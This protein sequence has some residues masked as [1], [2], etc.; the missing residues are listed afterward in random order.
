MK[1]IKD[2]KTPRKH[3]PEDNLRPP[4]KKGESGNL[5]G[6]PKGAS[7]KKELRKLVEESDWINKT[8]GETQAAAK[9]IAYKMV[10]MALD[11]D[12]LQAIKEILDRLYGKATQNVNMAGEMGVR[13]IRLPVK[14]QA[15]APIDLNSEIDD[16]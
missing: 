11:H 14:K 10:E 1:T 15:G 13:V 5:T 3:R 7:V 12:S 2:K 4:W 16:C 6:R 8:T 9:A